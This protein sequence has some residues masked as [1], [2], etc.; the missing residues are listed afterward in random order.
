MRPKMLPAARVMIGGELGPS[1]NELGVDSAYLLAALLTF[2]DLHSWKMP[3]LE[4]AKMGFGWEKQGR[5]S[6]TGLM[7][8]LCSLEGKHNQL[9]LISITPKLCTSNVKLPSMISLVMIRL[10]N[11]SHAEVERRKKTRDMIKAEISVASRIISVRSGRGEGP[12]K[13]LAQVIQDKPSEVLEACGI[14]P[15]EVVSLEL[16]MVELGIELEVLERQEPGIKHLQEIRLG[17]VTRCAAM[18]AQCV[19]R[20]YSILER[21]E[22]LSR[23][24]FMEIGKLLNDSETIRRKLESTSD[25]ATQV[26]EKCIE[27]GAL[28]ARLSSVFVDVNTSYVLCTV[29]SESVG[30]FCQ[31][32]GDESESILDG[33]SIAPVVPGMGASVWEFMKKPVPKHKRKKQ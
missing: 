23:L 18:E 26:V 29:N 30:A 6:A 15:D 4:M 14:G 9:L 12:Q 7:K 5:G 32:L 8:Y 22:D 27:K 17:L 1:D 3:R 19:G 20:V 21:S 33:L 10:G 16:V 25:E 24:E 28:S 13:S 2:M 31:S 11:R